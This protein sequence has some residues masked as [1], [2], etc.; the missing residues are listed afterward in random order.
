[1]K[2]SGFKAKTGS[3]LYKTSASDGTGLINI[4]FFNNKYVVNQLAEGEDYL[5]FGKVVLNMYGAK[6]MASP[7]FEKAEGKDRI[8]PVY[9]STQKLNSKAIERLVTNALDA[10]AGDIP[11]PLPQQLIKKYRLPALADALRMIHFPL[12]DEEVAAA[13]RRFVFEELLVLELGLLRLRSGGSVTAGQKFSVDYSGDFWHL[14][15]FSPTNAQR[16]AVNE[17]LGDMLSGR[18]MNRLLQGDVGSGKTAVAAALI[19]NA[20]KNSA[21]SALMAPTEV[22]AEQ[23]YRTLSKMLGGTGLNISLLTGSVPAAAKR[24][25]KARLA[26]GE[27]DLVIGTHALIQKDVEFNRLGLVITDEQHRFGVAQ[28]NALKDKGK[29]PHVFVMSATPIPRTLA[30]IIY[31]D[32][33]ISVLDELPPGRQPIE[34]YRVNTSYTDRILK[35]TQKALDAGRQ[36]YIICPL[37]EEGES[38]LIPATEYE[39]HLSL[40]YF[41]NYSVGL[42]H[43]QMKPSEKDAVMRGFSDGEIRLL[44]S[45]VVV[46]VGVDVPNATVMIIENAERFGL[47]QLHQLRGRIGRGEHKSTCILVS[48]AQNAQATERFKVLCETTDGFKIA[49]KDLEMRGPGDFFGNRQ[50]GL[51][52][53][54]IANV[55]T[56]TRVLY[57]AQRV[58]LSMLEND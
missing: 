32:L 3:M 34:T 36:A 33:D 46:E 19:Y 9:R 40:T 25:I 44:V 23:H 16:R 11:D 47:S 58:A 45:T 50:H 24:D 38:D 15:P 41:K 28:R 31:G 35:F 30:M 13:R 12:C 39:R 37:V 26:S 43:G 51:P 1:Y 49:D 21:Q 4:T 8:R 54:K 2:P 42:L 5:F 56:D 7:R 55:V 29:A 6:E 27:T 22:L 53:L 48:D 10:F 17:A 57:E 18:R 20:A 52:D 14:L